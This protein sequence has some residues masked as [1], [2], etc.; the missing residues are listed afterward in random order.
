MIWSGEIV[1]SWLERARG[2]IGSRP[3]TDVYSAVELVTQAIDC[4][5]DQEGEEH[6]TSFRHGLGPRYANER[7][8]TKQRSA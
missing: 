3:P 2:Y 8:S 6:R 1:P 5:P 7:R 4:P